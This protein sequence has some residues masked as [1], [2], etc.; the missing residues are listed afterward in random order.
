MRLG[1]VVRARF[2]AVVLLPAIPE[3]RYGLLEAWSNS[4]E[5]TMSYM[6][7][8]PNRYALL[9]GRFASW[10]IHNDLRRVHEEGHN[11]I[12]D[13]LAQF[14]SSGFLESPPPE[15][16][17]RDLVY[18][19]TPYVHRTVEG[20]QVPGHLGLL[21]S[22]DEP[23]AERK[24]LMI[25]AVHVPVSLETARE[26]QLYNCHV[27]AEA[28][29]GP[30]RT[31]AP[32]SYE[33]ARGT[34]PG[35]RVSFIVGHDGKSRQLPSVEDMLQSGGLLTGFQHFISASYSRYGLFQLDC[36]LSIPHHEA[37]ELSS[38]EGK[39]KL[40]SEIE[41][42]LRDI[43]K[44]LYSTR[45]TLMPGDVTDLDKLLGKVSRTVPEIAYDNLVIF[46]LERASNVTPG[47]D[48]ERYVDTVQPRVSDYESG[49]VSPATGTHVSEEFRKHAEIWERETR[50]TSSL[51]EMSMHS[52]YQHI[53]G[54]GPEV[55]PSIL[56]ELQ[57]HPNH[58]FW[59]LNAITGEDP[60]LGET[61]LTGAAQAWLAWGKEKGII[62]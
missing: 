49:V 42:P 18:Q 33:F 62:T 53:I 58:W 59:A 40:R 32:V 13:A 14:F 30:L 35:G 27:A 28:Y 8:T 2:L 47:L 15:Y 45:G 54:L 48:N 5:T 12:G 11:P 52:S 1:R 56:H 29:A 21:L 57:R 55:V 26:A 46:A 31:I 60:A 3:A 16:R 4:C 50:Y 44:H 23:T 61:T 17:P 34:I 43:E 10:V 41:T 37:N 24:Y 51:Q 6:H 39:S 38:T 9:H 20:K 22:V 19:V 36:Q 25:L 7:N